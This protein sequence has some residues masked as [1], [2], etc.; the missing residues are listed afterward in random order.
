MASRF[1]N[2]MLQATNSSL[3]LSRE[4]FTSFFIDG[5]Q[6]RKKNAPKKRIQKKNDNRVV[7][8]GAYAAA[9]IVWRAVNHVLESPVVTSLLLRAD[10]D[11]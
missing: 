5:F 2:V 6:N 7:L 8:P 3:D 11:E 4:V 10:R 1:E 9:G